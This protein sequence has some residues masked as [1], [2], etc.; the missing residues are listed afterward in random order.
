MN[1]HVCLICGVEL[2]KRPKEAF[3][4]FRDRRACC[5]EHSRVLA[6]ATNAERGHQQPEPELSDEAAR[7]IMALP[8]ARLRA[9]Y[10]E[11]PPWERAKVLQYRGLTP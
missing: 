2:V 10:E 9:A 1:E 6:N 3:A 8:G 4:D 7:V 5:R 11:L